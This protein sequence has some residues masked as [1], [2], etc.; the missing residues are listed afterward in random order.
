MN[1]CNRRN[2]PRLAPSG[3]CTTPSIHDS[4]GLYPQTSM[5]R[6]SSST[7]RFRSFRTAEEY[8]PT[9]PSI[10]NPRSR[11]EYIS[12]VD[13]SP[14][15]SRR[16]SIF[17][18]ASHVGGHQRLQL[19]TH[20][21]RKRRVREHVQHVAMLSFVPNAVL[22]QC[23]HDAPRLRIQEVAD[24]K[25]VTLDQ[26]I[27]SELRD[28]FRDIC[29]GFGQVSCDMKQPFWLSSIRPDD[30]AAHF[31]KIRPEASGLKEDDCGHAPFFQQLLVHGG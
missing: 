14:S 4:R 2:A 6:P 30:V 31:R 9:E 16:M 19:Q 17:K 23:A 29:D 8:P 11:S 24:A 26:G 1:S 10:W 3:S 5:T 21:R 13:R 20:S 28:L 27:V 7:S 25:A 15:S 18:R 12:P 22:D